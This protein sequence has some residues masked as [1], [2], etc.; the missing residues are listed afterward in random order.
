MQLSVHLNFGG[1]CREAFEYYERNLGGKIVAMMRADQAPGAPENAGTNIIHAR[2]S[3]AGMELIGN[4]VPAHVFQ[5]IRSVYLDLAADSAEHAEKLWAALSVDGQV[6]IPLGEQF[7]A[8]RFG[9]VRT[10]SVCFGQ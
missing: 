3:L 2:L 10:G 1:N 9:Q 4:D 8:T 7:F 5:P 6:G